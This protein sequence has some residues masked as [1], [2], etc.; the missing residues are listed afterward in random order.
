MPG[1]DERRISQLER[2]VVTLQRQIERDAVRFRGAEQMQSFE[3]TKATLD[4]DDRLLIE[5]SANGYRKAVIRA[6]AL[7][8]GSAIS[9]CDVQTFAS[10]GAYHATAIPIID[11]LAVGSAVHV[12]VN[13]TWCRQSVFWRQTIVTD[14]SM[15]RTANG[16]DW[17]GNTV[18]SQNDT[19]VGGSIGAMV[20]PTLSGPVS[21]NLY[22]PT[23]LSS[24]T[25]YVQIVSWHG[26]YHAT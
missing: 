19:P 20:S 11:S 10:D 1:I 15:F 17:I 5:N 3:L 9:G 25:P 2:D 14:Y 24:G 16:V 13:V 7:G 21:L 18:L 6:G 22:A 23:C 26:V 4:P 8:L 12:Y